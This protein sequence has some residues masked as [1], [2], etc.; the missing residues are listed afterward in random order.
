MQVYTTF[1]SNEQYICSQFSV[2]IHSNRLMKCVLTKELTEA[3]NSM[4][5]EQGWNGRW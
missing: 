5:A 3:P 1:I 2:R 4:K